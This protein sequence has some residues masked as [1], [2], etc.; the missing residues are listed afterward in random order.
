MSE[1]TKARDLD[2]AFGVSGAE[3]AGHSFLISR[4]GR[5]NTEIVQVDPATAEARNLTDLPGSNQRYPAWSPDGRQ[6]VFTSDRD[7]TANLY[8]MPARGGEFMQLTRFA[9]PDVAYFPWFQSSS[10]IVFGRSEVEAASICTVGLDGFALTTVAR[11]RDPHPSPDGERIAFTRLQPS[12]YAVFVMNAD[13][14]DICQITPAQNS[15]GAVTPTFSPDGNLI[16]YSDLVNGCL[17][18][19]VV[20]LASGRIRQLTHLGQ[21]ATSPAWSPCGQY[22]TFRLTDEPYWIDPARAAT[23]HAERHP[24]KRPVWIVES[25]GSHPRIIDA[26]REGCALDGSRAVWNPTGKST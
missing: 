8:L 19:F 26:M 13:G 1:K 4:L 15:I 21:F 9:A 5:G 17:E 6:I 3:L 20:E 24:R 18:L 11:G 7:G 25:D 10:R 2:V 22:L 14:S 23:V 16:A 12:G